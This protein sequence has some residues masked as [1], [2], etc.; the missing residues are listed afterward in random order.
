M[1]IFMGRINGSSKGIYL[2]VVVRVVLRVEAEVGVC[3]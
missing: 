3:W 1:S 2:W